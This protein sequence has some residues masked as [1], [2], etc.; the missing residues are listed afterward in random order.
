MK[1]IIII[2]HR[3]LKCS[4]AEKSLVTLHSMLIIQDLKLI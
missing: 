2:C 3:L 1:K 4:V